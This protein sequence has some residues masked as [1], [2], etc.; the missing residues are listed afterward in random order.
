MY[1]RLRRE[2]PSSRP[3]W[4]TEQV[5]S[6]LSH[7]SQSLSQNE[8]VGKARAVP[9]WWRACL[10]CED[11]G[12][13][14]ST[15]KVIIESVRSTVGTCV[16]LLHVHTHG[17]CGQPAR[18]SSHLSTLLRASQGSNLGPQALAKVLTC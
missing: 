18:V 17:S 13:L 10:T 15:S 14:H 11:Q 2:N 3:S 12:T 1:Q 4:A 8:K 9:Q 6:Q 16:H 7:L 5:Q